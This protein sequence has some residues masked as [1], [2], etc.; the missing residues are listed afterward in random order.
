MMQ[1]TT[2]IAIEEHLRNLLNGIIHRRVVTEP[3]NEDEILNKNPFGARVVPMEVWKG[4]K[5]ERSF[6]TSLGQSFFEQIA[7]LIAIDTGATA[8]N[9]YTSTININTFRNTYINDLLGVQRSPGN[10]SRPD[11]NTELRELLALNNRDT[12]EVDIISDLYVCRTDGQEEYYS[13]KTVKPNLDQTEIAKRSMLRLKAFNANSQVYFALP[14]NPAGEGE[15]YRRGG[16]SVPY[17]IFDMDND[18][19][20]LIGAEFWN[21][22]GQN[23][24]TYDELLEIFENV[25]RTYSIP[26]ILNEYF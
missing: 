14:Y 23:T 12:T 20:V 8:I 15:I 4:S 24:T 2:R 3:F 6:V 5:F 11:W 19:C 16:H 18:S 10:Q 26:R 9:Q 13:M 7:K 25:G 1:A 17:R 21:Q 22:L